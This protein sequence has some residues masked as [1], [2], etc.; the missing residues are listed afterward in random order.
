M[1][2]IVPIVTSNSIQPFPTIELEWS[3]V[4]PVSVLV[5]PVPTNDIPVDAIIQFWNDPDWLYK[6]NLTELVDV[7]K[8]G[9]VQ[10]VE[11][12]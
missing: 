1:F 3:I 2:A 9:Y 8:D 7:S 10:I 11:R 6:R 4:K 5:V 12:S